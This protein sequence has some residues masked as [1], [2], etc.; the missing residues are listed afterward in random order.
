MNDRP[1]AGIADGARH[2]L[3]TVLPVLWFCV[4]GFGV[5]MYVL[6]DGFV[7]GLGI[8]APFAE[9]EHQLRPHDEH[10]RADLGRQRDLAGARRRRLAG[11]VP[12]GLRDRCCRR[13]TCRCC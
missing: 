8:L 13:C 9:D 6:L 1:D 11:G 7:L 10:R 3:A 2:E 12:E 5:L 4:I